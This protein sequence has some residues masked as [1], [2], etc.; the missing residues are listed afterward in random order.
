MMMKKYAI[1]LLILSGLA[2]CGADLLRN[3]GFAN[4]GGNGAPAGWTLRD[5]KVKAELPD[6]P[7]DHPAVTAANGTVTL[8]TQEGRFEVMLIQFKLPLTRGKSYTLGF[9]VKGE[10]APSYRTV[11]YWQAK[12]AAGKRIWKNT[13]GA[14]IPAPKERTS[15]VIEFTLPDDAAEPYLY[16]AASGIGKVEISGVQLR[17]PGIELTCSQELPVF[18]PD[19]AVNFQV[20]FKGAP[21]NRIQYQLKDFTGKVIKESAVENEIAVGTP[22]NGY[23]ELAATELNKAGDKVSSTVKTFAVIP[24]VP[25]AVRNSDKNQYGV[26]VNP[27]TS[28]PFEQKELDVKYTARIGAKY[29]RTHR[30]NWGRIQSAPDAPYNWGEADAEMELY[31]QYGIRPVATIGWPVPQWAS[32]AAGTNVPNRISY[33]PKDEYLPALKKFYSALAAR[34][35]D[36]IA[37]YEVGNEVDASNFWMGRYE[38][39]MKGDDQAVFNDYVEFYIATA[40]AVLEGNPGAK[41]GPGTTGGVPAGHSYRPWLDM[42][43]SNPEALRY[44]NIFC[45]HYKTDIPAIRKVMRKHGKEVPIVLTEIGG[46]VKTESY[47]LTPADF[48][49]I[50]KRTYSQYAAQLNQ[51]GLALC[52]FLLRQIPGVREGWVS[53]ML[54]ADFGIRPE[55]VAYATLIR[56]TGNAVFERELNV[57]ANASAGW[58][59]AYR[60]KAPAGTLNLVMLND[61]DTATVTLATTEKVLTVIDVMG[62]E[63]KVTSANGKIELTMAEDQPLFICGEIGENPGEVKHPEPV[64]VVNRILTLENSG[65]EL[66][67]GENITG[68]RKVVDEAEGKDGKA[69]FSVESDTQTFTEGSRSLRM[70]SEAQTRW[71][72]V[73]C[74]LP[75]NEIPKPAAGE[76][77][78]FTVH[79][80]Q[81]GD[82]I[83]GTGAGLTLAFRAANMRRV[84]FNDG[85]WSRGTFDWTAKSWTSRQFPEFPANTAKITLEFYLGIAT[86]T[87]WVDNVRVEMKLYRKS[88]ASSAY[89]N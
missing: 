24:E 45:P 80:D 53:E 44:T 4:P 69:P 50:I 3:A 8:D 87:V 13:P 82:Q 41:I 16:F 7:T 51:G 36:R 39:A 77:L 19:Q 84:G 68:W 72:G 57:T 63:R 40:S 47:Q 30:L 59:E 60:I 29:L 46:L 48:R 85:N 78:V 14:W 6:R 12:D 31:R 42:F 20:R 5:T 38:N 25:A 54:G 88:N 56:L 28:Y 43:W 79:Y 1:L 66:V 11:V 65:F 33:F 35:G 67:D 22:G 10:G 32:S 18:T 34:Y 55:Y 23:F 71:Y 83:V 17:E 61:A 15:R 58:A 70:S 62:I 27:H 37:Y 86:G 52:K 49:Q 74:E 89:I 76:Y 81:K 9:E 73:L 64:V 75:M 26:M 2:L 21:E